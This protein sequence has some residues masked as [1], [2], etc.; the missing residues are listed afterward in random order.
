MTRFVPILMMTTGLLLGCSAPH[1]L[2]PIWRM[3]EAPGA[4]APQ[5][6]DESRTDLWRRDA[7]P[8]VRSVATATLVSPEVG[9]SWLADQLLRDS[10]AAV[11]ERDRATW[12]TWFGI[13]G[14]RLSLHVHWEFDRLFQIERVADPRSG[15]TFQLRDDRGRMVSPVSIQ[16]VTTGRTERAH[17]ADFLLVF[18]GHD[19]TGRPL[20]DAFTNRV[21][22]ELR[23]APGKARMTWRFRPEVGTPELP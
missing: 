7:V 17:V 9:R 20:V 22:L 5:P 23:G 14:D 12:A 13:R 1:R 16:D 3:G 10:R 6:L 2:V 18:P 4:I 11:E 8:G 21:D 19:R 15:W